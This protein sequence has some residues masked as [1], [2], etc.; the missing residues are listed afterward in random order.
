M[1]M[2]GPCTRAYGAPLGPQSMLARGPVE[3]LGRVGPGADGAGAASLA[4]PS[5]WVAAGLR[6]VPRYA[7][8]CTAPLSK[9]RMFTGRGHNS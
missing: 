2:L 5:H 3:R 1:A 8:I 6:I 4:P 9:Y 7:A